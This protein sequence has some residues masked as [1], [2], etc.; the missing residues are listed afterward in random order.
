[1]RDA[2]AR[3]R[4]PGRRARALAERLL[5]ADLTPS[6]EWAGLDETPRVLGGLRE[7]LPEINDADLAH[8]ARAEAVARTA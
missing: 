2:A 8:R 5:R 7:R 1:M 6:Q 3:S 4:G